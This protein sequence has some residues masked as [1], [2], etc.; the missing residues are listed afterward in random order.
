VKPVKDIDVRNLWLIR[1][2]YIFYF[3]GMGAIFP[4]LTLF[5]VHN[6]LSGTQIGVLNALVALGCF[7]SAPIWGWLS[8][9]ALRPRL[10]L[11]VALVLDCLTLYL[12]SR[13]TAFL[14]I[15][16]FIV[17]NALAAGGVNPQSQ[18]QALLI[19]EKNRTGYGSIRL[20]GSLGYALAALV[21]GMAIQQTTLLAGFYLFCALTLFA[22][23]IL[24]LIRNHL[25]DL[26]EQ[27]PQVRPT[28]TSISS[29]FNVIF[30]N[31]Q[32]VAYLFALIIVA[33]MSNGV[34]F[35]SV[36]LQRLGASEAVIGRL[37]TLGA[38]VEI[39]MML[40]ADRLMRKKGSTITLIMGWLFY[41]V[42]LLAIV[43]HPS[44]ASFIIYRVILGLSFSLYAVSCTYFVVERT[45]DQQ[46][47]TILA[48][49]SVTVGNLINMIASPISGALFDWAGPYWLYVIALAGYCIA[50][51]IIFF[52]VARKNER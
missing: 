40:L 5:Y 41:V 45:P 17:L 27:A 30:K 3:G 6:G 7:I 14:F 31:P 23:L 20:C 39:P 8:D 49:F 51:A 29:I 44:I 26:P 35:E 43:I 21:S 15:T 16:I 13:Q 9:N 10:I 4:F 11:Q 1:L 2:Y 18:I 33:I 52:S 46:A 24:F 34:S 42:A 50:A 12:V 47:G 48:F 22:A 32:L 25:Q 37:S 19:S 38:L 28:K 36:Y